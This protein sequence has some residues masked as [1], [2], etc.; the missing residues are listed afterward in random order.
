MT[1]GRTHVPQWPDFD[2]RQC[3]PVK[4][5]ARWARGESRAASAATR[6]APRKSG[7]GPSGRLSLAGHLA[8]GGI[9]KLHLSR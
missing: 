4:L 9:P 7:P 3:R 5:E 2:C 1:P 8:K 6:V